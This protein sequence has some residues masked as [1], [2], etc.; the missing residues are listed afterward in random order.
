MVWWGLAPSS[1]HSYASAQNSY[2][3]FCKFQLSESHLPVTLTK[4]TKWVAYLHNRSIRPKTIKKYLSGLRSAHV[5][6][7]DQDLEV[8]HSP[9]LERM[10]TGIKRLKGDLETRERLPISRGLL[11]QLVGYRDGASHADRTLKAAYCLAFAAFLRAGE[12]TYTMGDRH[13]PEFISYHLTRQSITLENDRLYV[14]LPASK[15]DPF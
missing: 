8:F 1:R 9:T 14:F 10:I 5:D 6:V 4:L 12:F 11:L 7:G 3:F 2:Y 13:D 15:T